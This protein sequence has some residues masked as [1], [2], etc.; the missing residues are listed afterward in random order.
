MRKHP[1]CANC[2]KKLKPENRASYCDQDCRQGKSLISGRVMV[3][4]DEMW[5]GEWEHIAPE[6][7]RITG[8]RKELI[9]VC[10]RHRVMPKALVKPSSQGKG[11]EMSSRRF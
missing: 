1:N 10:K 7:I 2:G 4:D 8:G 6:P 5:N 3:N 9:E 11:Y